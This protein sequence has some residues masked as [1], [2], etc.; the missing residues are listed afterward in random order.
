MDQDDPLESFESAKY[1]SSE[2]VGAICSE[3]SIPIGEDCGMTFFLMTRSQDT[4]WNPA[5]RK[6]SCGWYAILTRKITDH[7]DRWKSMFPKL[8]HAFQQTE[9]HTSSDSDPYCIRYMESKQSNSTSFCLYSRPAR[10]HWR[11]VI[12]HELMGHVSI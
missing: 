9:G 4:L 12:T 10:T 11:D 8:R 7:A 3:I 5:S 2:K 6:W 1:R